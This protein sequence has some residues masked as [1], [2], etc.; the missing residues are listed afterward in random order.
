MDTKWKRIS[1]RVLMRGLVA[2]LAAGLA[3]WTT[4]CS[5]IPDSCIEENVVHIRSGEGAEGM[6]PGTVTAKPGEYIRWINDDTVAHTVRF[7]DSPGSVP[8]VA[9]DLLV[10]PGAEKRMRVHSSKP[11]GGYELHIDP[12]AS[13]SG[14][15]PPTE[16]QVVVE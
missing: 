15:W 7:M 8:G 16:P 12:P 9:F 14:T 6:V 1:R 13:T 10:P 4:S 2:G 3:L 5:C 11:A